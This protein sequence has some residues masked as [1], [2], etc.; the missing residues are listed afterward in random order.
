[1]PGHQGPVDGR[2]VHGARAFH[3]RIEVERWHRSN[4]YIRHCGWYFNDRPISWPVPLSTIRPGGADL[5]FGSPRAIGVDHLGQAPSPRHRLRRSD[6]GAVTDHPAP[7][8]QEDPLLQRGHRVMVEPADEVAIHHVQ[9]GAPELG[10]GVPVGEGV[11]EA[12]HRG[13][14]RLERAP[15]A[16]AVHREQA[17]VRVAD[18]G[19]RGR[20]VPKEGA[21]GLEQ[22]GSDL[23]DLGPRLPQSLVALGH[24][25]HVDPAER[26]GEA[27]GEPDHDVG[28]APVGR[29]LD[30]RTLDRGQTEE[31]RRVADDRRLGVG[32]HGSE[33]STRIPASR[34]VTD[35]LTRRPGLATLPGRVVGPPEGSEGVPVSQS[36]TIQIVYDFTFPDGGAK[37]YTIALDQASLS[38]LPSR[39][40]APPA[41]A[42][43]E[44]HQCGHCPL[45]PAEHPYCPVA[46][47]LSAIVEFFKDKASVAEATVTVTTA[48]RIYVK[49]LPLQRGIF[50]VFGLVMATSACPYMDF[51]KPM[52]RFHL[53]F[54]TA[55][56][57]IVRSVSMYLL[58]QYFVAKR[59]GARAR[60][61]PRA[62]RDALREHPE[63]ERRHPRADQGRGRER[64]RP[65]RPH[66][67]PGLRRSPDHGDREGSLEDRA[68]LL[69]RSLAALARYR[70]VWGQRLTFRP[71]RAPP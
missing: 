12:H 61:R 36:S 20:A 34:H 39:Q 15:V 5:G 51:L 64:R 47:N 17:L 32:R 63:G 22:V 53:P 29:E 9:P 24:A 8:D 16:Q 10:P 54:S 65:Q 4:H 62:A 7:V 18:E 13:A 28:P 3:I 59:G 67:P 70:E 37:S 1:M 46:T 35:T 42:R 49:Q 19:V 14:R 55:E 2:Q 57:T 23:D 25:V 58:H 45:S 50:G 26:T 30:R 56:E 44:N 27:A 40:E 71:C 41:W 21:R 69:S 43:L 66:H 48:E 11:G 6:H 68:A 60:P 38:Y 52:A 33:D 31:R